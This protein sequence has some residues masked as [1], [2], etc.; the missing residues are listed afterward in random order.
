MLA[1][2]SYGRRID[3]IDSKLK[4]IT[5]YKTYIDDMNKQ[6]HTLTQ[7]FV[8]LEGNISTTAS[9]ING[10]RQTV[11]ETSAN[12]HT[13]ITDLGNL[14]GLHSTI[15][16][17]VSSLHGVEESLTYLHGRISEIIENMDEILDTYDQSPM[18]KLKSIIEDLAELTD[19]VS[20]VR[21]ELCNLSDTAEHIQTTVDD[22]VDE[23]E[24]GSLCHRIAD[25]TSK[26]SNLESKIESLES[27]LSSVSSKVY[28]IRNVVERSLSGSGYDS[29]YGRLDFISSDIN[30]IRS[31]VDT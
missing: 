17:H 14:Q 24:Y 30:S 6:T 1:L 25:I 20:S 11:Q 15:N 10:L 3:R 5:N 7:S 26:F 28:D 22:A 2:G 18:S 27:D 13:L 12:I 19:A 9:V 23:Y 4:C 16:T 8:V 29:L 31:K 21:S